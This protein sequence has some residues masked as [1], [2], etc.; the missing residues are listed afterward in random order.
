M[1]VSTKLDVKPNDWEPVEAEESSRGHAVSPRQKQKKLVVTNKYHNLQRGT[2]NDI[3]ASKP[4]NT[5]AEG[6]R[7][8]GENAS[9]GRFLEP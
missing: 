9:E 6:K 7:A 2:R 8:Y 5:N 4:K 1:K 3:Q